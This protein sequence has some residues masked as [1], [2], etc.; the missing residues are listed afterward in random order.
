MQV[1]F[2]EAR[3]DFHENGPK[4]KSLTLFTFYFLSFAKSEGIYVSACR[5]T[6][7]IK[8]KNLQGMVAEVSTLGEDGN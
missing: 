4:N 3:F 2:N 7:P 5:M 6:K 8:E 1:H